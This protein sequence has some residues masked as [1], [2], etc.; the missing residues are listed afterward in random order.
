[1]HIII[2]SKRISIIIMISS[3]SSSFTAFKLLIAITNIPYKT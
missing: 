2:S 3:S 1:M